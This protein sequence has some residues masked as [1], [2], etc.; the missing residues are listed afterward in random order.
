MSKIIN[1]IFSVLNPDEIKK[2]YRPEHEDIFNIIYYSASY[3]SSL[4]DSCLS[5][6]SKTFSMLINKTNIIEAERR[7]GN[8]G[9]IS[10]DDIDIS[11]AQNI[12]LLN[13]V[14]LIFLSLFKKTSIYKKYKNLIALNYIKDAIDLF[15]A[16][17]DCSF[18]TSFHITNTF[19]ND[20]N[21]RQQQQYEIYK[22][23]RYNE[24]RGRHK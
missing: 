4:Y 1:K 6:E 19:V 21:F 22:E 23:I 16:W 24:I 2:I 11:F 15:C 18:Y 13:T 14:N 5:N 3:D 20:M 8:G 12:M 17:F 9:D 10:F 7:V